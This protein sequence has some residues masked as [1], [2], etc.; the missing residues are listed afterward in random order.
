MTTR[1]RGPSAAPGPSIYECW[2]KRL[3]REL[4]HRAGHPAS[5]PRP[6]QLTASLPPGS[7]AQQSSGGC[8]PFPEQ[9]CPLAL[10]AKQSKVSGWFSKAAGSGPAAQASPPAGTPTLPQQIAFAQW[11]SPASCVTG[12]SEFRP[13]ALGEEKCVVCRAFSSNCSPA[14][15]AGKIFQNKL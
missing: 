10:W 9:P 11:S 1:A 8:G 15:S 2:Q 12:S 14:S 5:T 13:S 3:S 6:P 7:V 4:Y